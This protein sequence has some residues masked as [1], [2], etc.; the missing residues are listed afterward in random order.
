MSS[1]QRH[2]P[3]YNPP[4]RSENS[5]QF[6]LRLE[7]LFATPHTSLLKVE[8]LLNDAI[9]TITSESHRGEV[10]ILTVSECALSALKEI[11]SFSF[12]TAQQAQSVA[13]GLTYLEKVISSTSFDSRDPT[14]HIRDALSLIQPGILR[15]NEYL[16]KSQIGKE[17]SVDAYEHFNRKIDLLNRNPL[18]LRDE[19]LTQGSESRES[20]AIY[21]V[22]SDRLLEMVRNPRGDLPFTQ[23]IW[24]LRKL[25][26]CDKVPS[27]LS[28]LLREWTIGK[29]VP[30]IPY[31]QHREPQFYAAQALAQCA[32]DTGVTQF[33]SG[34]LGTKNPQN[35]QVRRTIV[36]SL[37]KASLEQLKPFL[38][39]ALR[40]GKGDTVEILDQ[41]LLQSRLSGP[42]KRELV[43]AVMPAIFDRIRT[44]KYDVLSVFP[45]L[46]RFNPDT[47][48]YTSIVQEVA[49]LNSPTGRAAQQFLA[50]TMRYRGP[51]IV[52][53]I[54]NFWDRKFGNQDR[55]TRLL[56]ASFKAEQK[57]RSTPA[58]SNLEKMGRVLTLGRR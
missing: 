26:A 10:R 33:L 39:Y 55:E 29:G 28:P 7:A 57:V 6:A 53:Q 12:T 19:L 23:R 52:S 31:F 36:D 41:C 16:Y 1:F 50:K 15:A 5:D 14:G 49:K 54:R 51:S 37:S 25:I 56:E 45:I 58:T 24:A 48:N 43:E 3:P 11:K 42:E 8:Q 30:H 47:L 21:A 20:V 4:S 9:Q 34:F 46:D 22:L 27:S 17:Q 44:G 40:H 2:Q 18:A 38:D 32:G 13:K 35:Q